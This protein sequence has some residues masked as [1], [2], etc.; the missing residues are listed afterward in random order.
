MIDDDHVAQNQ[1]NSTGKASSKA[2]TPPKP[3]KGQKLKPLTV[4]A[5]VTILNETSSPRLTFYYCNEGGESPEPNETEKRILEEAAAAQISRSAD[6]P[7][8][9]I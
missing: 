4:L 2:N 6:F 1:A 9:F 7:C 8:R 5:V 3:K